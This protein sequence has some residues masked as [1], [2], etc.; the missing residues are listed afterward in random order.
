MKEYALALATDPAAERE[1]LALL[2]RCYDPLTIARLQELGV[3]VGWRC[4]DVGAGGGSIAHW[5]SERVGPSGSVTAIDLDLRLLE[6]RASPTLSPMRLDV[7][8]EELPGDAH[9]V[10]SRLLLEHLPECPDVLQRMVRALRPGGWLVVTDT[11]F[12][13]MRVSEPDPAFD[14]VASAFMKAVRAAGWDPQLGPTLPR[15]LESCGLVEISAASWQTSSE[16]ATS[17]GSS[18]CP[19]CVCATCCSLKVRPRRT[20]T[21]SHAASRAE[22]SVFTASFRGRPR[23][24]PEALS[25]RSPPSRSRRAAGDT[26]SRSSSGPTLSRFALG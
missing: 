21:T 22:S 14:R 2:E 10:H 9:L 6:R 8:R 13:P 5:L 3:G 18:R 15:L 17:R 4:V 20:L 25:R 19:S 16:A 7:R 11:D 24:V 23:V 12:G 26:R 1:R